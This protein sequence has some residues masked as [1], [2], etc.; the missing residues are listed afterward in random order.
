MQDLDI[1]EDELEIDFM[2]KAKK[3]YRW[4]ARPDTLWLPVSEVLCKIKEPT[5]SGKFKRCFSINTKDVEVINK[6][7]QK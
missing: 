4:P 2:K 7:F 1:E 5:P 3:M 6:A